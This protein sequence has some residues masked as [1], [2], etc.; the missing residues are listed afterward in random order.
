MSLLPKIKI[1]IPV[2]DKAALAVF[3]RIL[4]AYVPDEE[5]SLR[6]D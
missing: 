5:T 4:D 1:I 6:L 2:Y 3:R